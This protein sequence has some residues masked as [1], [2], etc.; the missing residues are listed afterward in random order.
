MNIAQFQNYNQ[1]FQYNPPSPNFEGYKSQFSKRLD[2][3]LIKKRATKEDKQF[4]ISKLFNFITQKM[5]P[6]RS[7]GEGFHGRVYKIDDKYVL[8]KSIFVN[9][10]T[11]EFEYITKQKFKAL[12]TY[13][14][15]PVAKISGMSILKN[16]APNGT[17]A[18]VGV[19]TEFT[20]RN[21]TDECY[22]YYNMFSLP[23]L[24]DVPQKAFDNIA[25]DFKTLNKMG[26]GANNYQFDFLN[27]NNFV[28]SGKSL[29]ITDEIIST[30]HPNSNSISKMLDVFI[31]N[32]GFRLP[33]IYSRKNVGMRRNILDKIIL[34]GMREKLPFGNTDK[35]MYNWKSAINK[36]CQYK[37]P[38]SK[39]H[40]DLKT[41]QKIPSAKTRVEN[42]RKY[43]N[44]LK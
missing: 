14:G 15:E 44:E 9:T 11:L 20:K 26:R 28:I 2:Q 43:L 30:L 27:P 8:K 32:I 23:Q 39:V 18:T 1:Y 35:D 22:A 13:Y 19:P 25:K 5:R 33:A 31:N 4:L 7:V 36:L 41:L 6:N 38:A 21:L 3:V 37:T 24:A 10:D 29:R 34:A 40:S 16:V 12:K 17:H 42:T